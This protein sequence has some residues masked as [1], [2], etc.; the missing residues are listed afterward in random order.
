MTGL[1]YEWM[2]DIDVVTWFLILV[3]DTTMEEEG[4]D[5]TLNIILS[6]FFIWFLIFEEHGWKEN[7]S[8]KESI[9]WFPGLNFSLK[10]EKEGKS[11]LHLLSMLMREDFRCNL[12]LGVRL[13]MEML[14][15]LCLCDPSE[16]RI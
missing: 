12:Y 14:W 6:R 1:S 5:D 16:L 10:E 11:L 13:S 7:Q 15:G 9:R 4:F 2:C 3:S 8:E